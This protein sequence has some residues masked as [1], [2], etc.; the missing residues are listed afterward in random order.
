MPLE[1]WI[2]LQRHNNPQ[3]YTSQLVELALRSQVI[4]TCQNQMGEKQTEQDPSGI[5]NGNFERA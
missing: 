2:L 1:P 3:D 4:S 5:C